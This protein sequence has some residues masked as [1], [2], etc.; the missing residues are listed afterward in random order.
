MYETVRNFS[1]GLATILAATIPLQAQSTLNE[2]RD[3]IAGMVFACGAGHEIRSTGSG[4]GRVEITD[5]YVKGIAEG[6][7][8][9]FRNRAAIFSDLP[10]DAIENVYEKFLE[11][12]KTAM[13]SLQ[14]SQNN[15]HPGDDAPSEREM[16]VALE[17]ALLG[18][19]AI[20]KGDGYATENF[21]AG[22][23]IRILQFSKQD[24]RIP[25]SGSGWECTYLIS[26]GFSFYSNEGTTDG[27]RHADAVNTL[28]GL[29]GG[30]R[31]PLNPQTRRFIKSNGS[32]IVSIS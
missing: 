23:Q 20:R 31:S 25:S 11:C 8:F 18:R 4:T 22:A 14:Y 26:T 3:T 1:F 15:Y 32:W 19:G 16:K 21:L 6:N 28:F 30:T 13:T 12:M 17:D 10:A 29:F 5:S 9:V 24:C 7:D 27:N 2:K